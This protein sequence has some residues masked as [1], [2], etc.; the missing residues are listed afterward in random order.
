MLDIQALKEK[1]EQRLSGVENVSVQDKGNTR[2]YQITGKEAEFEI[3]IGES[4]VGY[5]LSIP[6][7]VLGRQI[8]AAE[9]TDNY[10]LDDKNAVTAMTIF[11]NALQCLDSFLKDQ[12]YIGIVG[13][14]RILAIPCDHGYVLRAAGRF[15]M[16]KKIISQGEFDNIKNN[17]RLIVR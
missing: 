14:K 16:D 3:A 1:V 7:E 15:V 5:E 12:I 13:K 8:G 17:L 6:K 2:T 9:D 4:W 11:N 10:A